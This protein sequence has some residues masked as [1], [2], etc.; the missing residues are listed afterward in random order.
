MAE[1]LA[2]AQMLDTEIRISVNEAFSRVTLRFVD[3]DCRPVFVTLDL[4]SSIKLLTVMDGGQPLIEFLEKQRKVKGLFTRTQ[5]C[6]VA[7]FTLFVLVAR[8]LIGGLL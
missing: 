8:D 6:I 2:I 4:E 1:T 7:G 5:V 3:Y